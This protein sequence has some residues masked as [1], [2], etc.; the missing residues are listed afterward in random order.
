MQVAVFCVSC[1]PWIATQFQWSN[2]IFIMS[3]SQYHFWKL[4]QFV[5]L[6]LYIPVNWIV[7]FSGRFSNGT[8]FY[9]Y[10]NE[11]YFLAFSTLYV[12]EYIC[13]YCVCILLIW[14]SVIF[15]SA[16]KPF[17]IECVIPLGIRFCSTI[18]FYL[19]S[20][21]KRINIMLEENLIHFASRS[22]IL[23]CII[24]QELGAILLAIGRFTSLSHQRYILIH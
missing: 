15:C 13:I 14:D 17:P 24:W 4:W 7:N 1:W 22:V 10:I 5:F 6:A 11:F 8:R 12:N 23:K 19:S 2:A 16:W 20:L 3:D 9:V 21:S 18:Y